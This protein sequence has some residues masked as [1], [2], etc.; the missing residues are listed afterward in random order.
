MNRNQITTYMQ[1]LPWK[2]LTLKANKFLPT[3]VPTFIKVLLSILLVQTAAELTWSLVTPSEEKSSSTKSHPST[4]QVN[5]ATVSLN[6]VSQYHLFGD[7]K[8][9][10]V[11]QQKVIDAPETRL[12]LTLKGVICYDRG[13]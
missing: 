8:K 13:K 5:T 3:F 4:S 2:E 1:D 10:P 7:A 6:D 9:Q 11:I 12:R